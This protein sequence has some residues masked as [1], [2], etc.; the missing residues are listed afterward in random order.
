S[1]F[2]AHNGGELDSRT[3]AAIEAVMRAAPLIVSPGRDGGLALTATGTGVARALGELL[4][5]AYG[6]VERGE[7]GRY[8][9]CAKCGSAFFDTTKNRSRVWCS[10]ALCGDQEK[11]REYRKRKAAARGNVHAEA[12]PP[13]T[14]PLS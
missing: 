11:A 9:A 12:H 5:T 4:V 3:G 2:Q 14:D 7:F 10:M 13:A 6:A 1:L 8:K